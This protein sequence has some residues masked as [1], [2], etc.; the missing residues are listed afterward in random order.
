VLD[1]GD[2]VTHTVPIFEGFALPHA[3]LRLDLAGRDLTDYLMKE[4]QKTNGELETAALF[5]AGGIQ[6]D[7]HLEPGKTLEVY[8]ALLQAAENAL[9]NDSTNMQKASTLTLEDAGS[10][11][12]VLGKQLARNSKSVVALLNN[13][14]HSKGMLNSATQ[15]GTCSQQLVFV[16]RELQKQT[17]G[18]RDL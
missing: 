4:T 16:G 13:D 15:V 14:T 17:D 2:G 10:Q 7:A 6:V 8:A 5:A 11:A 3:I 1:S 12:R 18:H 9:A